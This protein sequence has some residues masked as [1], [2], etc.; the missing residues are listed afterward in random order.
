VLRV[1]VPEQQDCVWKVRGGCSACRVA[2]VGAGVGLR[3]ELVPP[4]LDCV[5]CAWPP[6]CDAGR[7]EELVAVASVGRCEDV[8]RVGLQ[9]CDGRAWP[10]V[11]VLPVCPRGY[12]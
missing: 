6:D 9:T 5:S 11:G 1:S 8:L 2:G 3:V 10:V 4:D 12:E 7:G